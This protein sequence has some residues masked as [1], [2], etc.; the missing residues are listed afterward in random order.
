MVETSPTSA[1][2]VSESDFLLE[3]LVVPLNPPTEFG[4]VDHL[5]E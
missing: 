3:I 1:F 2:V 5:D 4:D